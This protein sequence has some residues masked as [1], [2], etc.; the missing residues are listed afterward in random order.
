MQRVYIITWKILCGTLG[1]I[2]LGFASLLCGSFLTSA[3]SLA[4]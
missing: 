3:I 4:F 1:A 2:T